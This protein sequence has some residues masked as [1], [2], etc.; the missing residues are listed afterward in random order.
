MKKVCFSCGR[1]MGVTGNGSR[2]TVFHSV[3]DECAN[4]EILDERLPELLRAIAVLGKQ[5]VAVLNK[6][7]VLCRTSSYH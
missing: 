5:N 6:H 1:L 4:R 2:N 3:C 7:Q